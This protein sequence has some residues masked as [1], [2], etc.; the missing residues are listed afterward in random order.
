MKR[1]VILVFCLFAIDVYA[2]QWVISYPVDE[3]VSLVGGCCNG[4]CNY[5]VGA[6]G[7]SHNAGVSGAYAM[8]V[9]KYGNHIA[10]T[11]NYEDYKA[12]FCSAICLEDGNAFVVGVKGGTLSDDIFDTLWIS[13]MTPDLEI[14]EEHNYSVE[15]PYKTWTI[16]VYLELDNYGD[17]IVLADISERISPIVAD[18]AYVV[19]RCD[20][21]GNVLQSRCFSE[22]HGPSGARPTGLK[23]VPNSD[24]MMILGRGF[25]TNNVH[26]ICYIDK[27]LNKIAVYPLPWL[28][29][30]WNY[31]DC[32]KDNGHFLM[33]SLTHHYNMA[34]E[35][36]YAA[37]FEVDD[38][39]NYIDTLV[40]DRADTSDYTAQ[41]GSMVRISDDVI[42]IATYW[43]NLLNGLDNDAVICMIDNGLNLKGTKRIKVANTKIR[44][45]HMQKTYDGG[46]LVYG[47]C[48][49]YSSGSMVY[50]WKMLPED[51]DGTLALPNQRDV[52][53]CHPAYPNPTEKF[54]NI[55][56]DNDDNQECVIAVYNAEGVKCFEQKLNN[57]VGLLT[58]DVTSFDRGTYIYEVYNDDICTQKGKFIK[59]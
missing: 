17:I 29:D 19:L 57:N 56:V 36:F 4:D 8:C 55:I 39:G 54:L 3:D 32:W 6:Y 24:N 42:Y 40:Y 46:C 30:N 44:I 33:S 48:R 26:S 45:M 12:R 27:D 35:S 34:G 9:D 10:K 31:T 5:I 14:I 15:E 37:V 2:Q 59:N 49:D 22:G 16:D 25:F 18:G 28:E 52:S 23:K 58:I 53:Q 20:S 47:Q 13:V 38:K 11:F 50:V 41:F 7:N 21:R 1:F 51:F 43:E